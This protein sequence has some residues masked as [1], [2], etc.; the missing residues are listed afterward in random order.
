MNRRHIWRG[1]GA[2]MLAKP[3]DAYARSGDPP[4][5]RGYHG[6]FVQ[7]EPRVDVS[8]VKLRRLDGVE[9]SLSS[10]RGK[11]M[12]VS[13]WASW[14]P[15]CR[16]ELPILAGLQARSAQDRFVIL[17]VSVDSD[18]AKAN[19]FIQRLRL[20][21]FESFIDQTGILASGPNSTM[22]AP[23]KLYGMPISYIIAHDG[24]LAGYVVGEAQ[25]DSDAALALL[26]SYA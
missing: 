10:Y 26:R 7:V 16:R 14:C 17:P 18:P 23:F 21:R 15:P 12:L 4:F 24:R 9:K 13:F 1:L 5:F 8:A 6:P 20:T 25:W 22:P 11:A 3:F 2:A 19:A